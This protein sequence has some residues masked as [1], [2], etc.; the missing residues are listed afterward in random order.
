MARRR[1]KPSD[2]IPT[3]AAVLDRL[4]EARSV[5]RQLRALLRVSLQIHGQ[6]QQQ[7]DQRDV[8]R[9]EAANAG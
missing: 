8:R 1:Y 6:P 2:H 9:G 3:P 4:A 5:V 7:P